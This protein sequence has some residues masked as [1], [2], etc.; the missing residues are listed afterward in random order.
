MADIDTDDEQDY[1]DLKMFHD[2]VERACYGTLGEEISI[3]D[4]FYSPPRN[5]TWAIE[6]LF[7]ERDF[8]IL[9][10][11]GGIGKSFIFMEIALSLASGTPLF[12]QFTPR[13]K[14]KILYLDHEMS[15][16]ITF[17][18]FQRMIHGRGMSMDTLGGSLL[19]RGD[20]QFNFSKQK[21]V[22]Q[23]YRLIKEQNI[24]FVMLDS[25]SKSHS[26]DGNSEETATA[27]FEIVHTLRSETGCG[28]MVIHHW[29]K[30]GDPTMPKAEGDRLR[31]TSA[32]RD[33]CDSHIAIVAKKGVMKLKHDKSRHAQEH[34]DILLKLEDDEDYMNETG[35]IFNGPLRV[36][37]AAEP[38]VGNT[39]KDK[40][41]TTIKENPDITQ[42]IL[43]DKLQIPLRTLQYH[44]SNLI[45]EGKITDNGKVKKG[46]ER[47][48]KAV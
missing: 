33:N 18:R 16:N 39:V 28:F 32:W 10:G 20:S 11:I 44:C 24:D 23:L 34:P 27:I 29:T 36:I 38:I 17:T 19:I 30:P 40:I 46:L 41:L 5:V 48:Y 14:Y 13:R 12:G 9:S 15:S 7:A 6:N 35:D 37:C 2:M 25:L 26:K 42:T 43:L 1:S 22:L 45:K 31:G 4:L 21:T 3:S 47:T 8:V